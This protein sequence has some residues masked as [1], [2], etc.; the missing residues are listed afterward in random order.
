M[1]AIELSNFGHIRAFGHRRAFR[2][3]VVEET[4]VIGRELSISCGTRTFGARWRASGARWRAFYFS[5]RKSFGLRRRAFD[6]W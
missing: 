1:L 5:C 4:L 2:L 3:L 6:L